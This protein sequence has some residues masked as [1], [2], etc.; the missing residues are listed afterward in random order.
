MNHFTNPKISPDRFWKA[1]MKMCG[2][3]ADKIKE[4]FKKMR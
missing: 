3:C 4:I 1:L 2:F